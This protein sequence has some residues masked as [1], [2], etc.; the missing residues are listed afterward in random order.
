MWRPERITVVGLGLLGASIAEAARRRWPGIG[1]T[2]VSSPGTLEKAA[3]AG[4]VNDGFMYPEIDSAVAGS[5][6]VILCTPID[7]IKSVLQAWAAHPPHTKDGC[8][9][10]DVG[11]TKAEICALGRRAFPDTSALFIGSHP[12]AGS[13]KTGLEA[14]DPLLFQNASW[15]LCPEY[16][17]PEE[18]V[19]RLQV[20]V[21]SLGARSARMT[22]ALHDVVAAHVSHLP[23]LLSTA[24]AGFIGAHTQV[25]ENCLQIAGPGFRDMTRLA[26]S[27]FP[28]WDPI[29][30]T[31]KKAVR[32][33]TA[34]FQKHLSNVSESLEKTGGA[35][36]YF[37]EANRLRGKLSTS[38]KGFT[39][40]LTEI[41]V[42]LEDRPGTL[43][44]ALNPL[45]QRGLNVQ[46]LEIL[47]VREGEAGVLMMAFRRPE[48]A[49][50][51]LGA[52][53]SAGFQGRMR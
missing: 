40:A 33:V 20:F 8:I 50:M 24:L 29:L 51:A 28:V 52:L 11:S 21:E 36:D 26:A 37:K 45:A 41:L 13:E 10:T 48:E 35:G 30:R 9:I 47:K 1:I 12:M 5:D 17:A 49:Q 31:N 32:E 3:S 25:V 27:S 22:P 23:Q 19:A 14:R 2:G 4:L 18:A 34:E 46:D 38:K 42:D 43:L 7:N 44:R 6:L 39:T 53:A 16:D 15:V